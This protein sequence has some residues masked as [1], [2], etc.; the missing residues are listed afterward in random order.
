MNKNKKHVKTITNIPDDLWNEIKSILPDKK[1]ENTIGRSI[2]P[3]RKVFDGI[4]FV[5]R[6]GFHWKVLPKVVLVRHFIKIFNN[7][8]I[9]YF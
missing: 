8:K 2:V 4:L 1:P 7:G 6:I 9:R 5:L 3:Y